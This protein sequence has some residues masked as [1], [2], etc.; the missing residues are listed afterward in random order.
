MTRRIRLV[1]AIVAA[2]L[3]FIAC[4]ATIIEPQWFELLFDESPDGGDGSL[5]TLAAVA[6]SAIACVVFSLIGRREWRLAR[7]GSESVATRSPRNG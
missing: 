2:A 3:S 1:A 4:V 6:V 7:R 5:E